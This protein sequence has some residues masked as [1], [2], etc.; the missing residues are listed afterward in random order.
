VARG[1]SS[2]LVITD[3]TLSPGIDNLPTKLHNAIGLVVSLFTPRVEG[4]ART[5]A[6]WTDRTGN[7]RNG[8]N[9]SAFHEGERHGIIL[10]HGVPY[11]IWLEVRF[12]GRYGIINDTI[13]SQGRELMSAFRYILGKA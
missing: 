8:L 2:G 7:A 4:Y 11:G 5:N 1:R 3:D 6:P 13:E 10:A 9:A 12:E